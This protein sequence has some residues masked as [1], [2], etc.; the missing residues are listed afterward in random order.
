MDS[1]LLP[2]DNRSGVFRDRYVCGSNP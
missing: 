1:K 2:F